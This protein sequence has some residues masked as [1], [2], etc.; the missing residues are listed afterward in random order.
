MKCLCRVETGCGVA[1]PGGASCRWPLLCLMVVLKSSL[2]EDA[3]VEWMDWVSLLGYAN[4]F[5]MG[6]MLS[7]GVVGFPEV[8]WVNWVLLA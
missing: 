5:A 7:A 4:G 8:L 6:A 1:Q 2:W 3:C